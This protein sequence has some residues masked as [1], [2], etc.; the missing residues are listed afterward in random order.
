MWT[1]K[2]ALQA[3][4]RT[5][6]ELA[7]ESL[8]TN[9]ILATD[10]LAI[11]RRNLYTAIELATA[12]PMHG[13]LACVD[14]LRANEWAAGFVPGYP[15]SILRAELATKLPPGHLRP[16]LELLI[17]EGAEPRAQTFITRFWDQ[18][19]GWLPAAER[20]RRF[21]RGSGVATNHLHD[22]SNYIASEYAARV[23]E[24]GL[25]TA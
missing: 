17:P 13:P 19:Y 24:Y 15:A 7:R 21:Q 3:F 22:Y 16:A 18:R 20:Q 14:L 9:Y 5:L 2:L 1:V 12:I 10:T 8:C 11:P 23:A 4:R 6:P 25:P